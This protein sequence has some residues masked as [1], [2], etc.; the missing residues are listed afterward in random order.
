MAGYKKEFMA[1]HPEIKNIEMV[2]VSG[3]DYYTKVQA[4]VAADSP[5]GDVILG[6]ISYRAR[7]FQLDILQNLEEAPFNL[8]K[9]DFL[10]YTYPVTSFKGNT[11][12]LDENINS[13]GLAYKTN[14]AQKYLGTSNVDQLSKRF[15]TWDGIISAGKEIYSKSG[16]KAFFFC[17]W[18][19]MGGYLNNLGSDAWTKDN[20]LTPYFVGTLLPK[21][22]ELLQKMIAGH[23]FDPDVPDAWTPAMSNAVGDD[24]HLA[25]FIPTWGSTS[26]LLPGDKNGAGR[27]RLLEPP[28]RLDLLGRSHVQ[29]LEGKQ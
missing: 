18:Q 2:P 4:A 11:V 13:T 9:S 19:D 1:T 17:T 10:S 25:T 29:H 14:V 23:T 6:E 27:W 22:Y 5:L 21:R 7:L 3:S 20:M 15:S 26:I 28:E 24:N 12:A 8:K 16:G